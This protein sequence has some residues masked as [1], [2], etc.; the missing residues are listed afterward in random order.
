KL[1]QLRKAFDDGLAPGE[2]IELKA[3]FRTPTGGN[4]WMWV[5]VTRWRGKT[6]T[7]TLD[8]N[9]A[10]IPDLK[11]GQ[12]VQIWQDDVFDYIRRFSDGRIEGNT[13]GPILKK[14][15]QGTEPAL[16]SRGEM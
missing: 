11:A 13:T 16:R 5:E 1:P 7:G 8:N 14:L 12:V 3:P 2:F 4:E 9:P 15:E 10:E 6:I